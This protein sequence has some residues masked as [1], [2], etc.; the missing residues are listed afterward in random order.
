VEGLNGA[1]EVELMLDDERIG[2]FTVKP[3]PA[4]KGGRHIRYTDSKPLANLHLTLLDK[5]GVRLDSF[6]DS[7]GKIPEVVEP[8]S[9]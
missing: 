7:D 9:V 2:L 3:P 4:R 6:A 1:H 5:T 8:L